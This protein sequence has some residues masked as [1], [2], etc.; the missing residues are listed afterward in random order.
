MIEENLMTTVTKIRHKVTEQRDDIIDFMR[1][2]VAIPSMNSKVG[3]VG[4]RIQAEMR[5]LG[6]EEARFDK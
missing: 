2:I 4:E 5:K 1:E 3:P 6:F